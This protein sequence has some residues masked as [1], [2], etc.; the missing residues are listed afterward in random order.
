MCLQIFH[1]LASMPIELEGYIRP[2]CIILTIFIAMPKFM[3]DKVCLEML[4]IALFGVTVRLMLL[5][6]LLMGDDWYL[7]TIVDVTILYY[8]LNIHELYIT[9]SYV[10]LTFI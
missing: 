6:T 5:T 3:W 7:H 10:P 2:G 8:L 1:W 9:S 4:Y